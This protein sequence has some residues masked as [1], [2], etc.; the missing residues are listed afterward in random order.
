LNALTAQESPPKGA[1]R[2]RD[3][4]LVAPPPEIAISPDGHWAWADPSCIGGAV[5][6]A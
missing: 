6:V 1:V 3:P 4:R 5:P 2:S